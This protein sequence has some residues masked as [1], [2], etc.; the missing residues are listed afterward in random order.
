MPV[1]GHAAL[2]TVYRPSINKKV[3]KLNLV[4]YQVTISQ[5]KTIESAESFL[6]KHGIS[7]AK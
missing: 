5:L 3:D 4:D 2:G 1:S 6:R 7:I